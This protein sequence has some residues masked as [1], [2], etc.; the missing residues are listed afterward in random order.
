MLLRSALF[1]VLIIWVKCSWAFVTTDLW[2]LLAHLLTI[3]TQLVLLCLLYRMH[4]IQ[5]LAII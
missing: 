5:C 3:V 2:G 4:V 1:F